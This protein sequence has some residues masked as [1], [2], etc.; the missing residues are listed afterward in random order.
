MPAEIL[1]VQTK[2]NAAAIKYHAHNYSFAQKLQSAH[3]PTCGLHMR[4][5]ARLTIYV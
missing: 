1:L 2:D 3:A 5:S 4:L